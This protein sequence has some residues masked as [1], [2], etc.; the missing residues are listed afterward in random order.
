MIHGALVFINRTE[1]LRPK[2][3]K[4][5]FSDPLLF[6]QT[7]PELMEN[8]ET[9]D[10]WTLQSW[11]EAYT[12]L[13]WDH[14]K[15]G[16]RRSAGDPNDDKSLRTYLERRLNED[17]GNLLEQRANDLRDSD[18]YIASKLAGGGAGLIPFA[19]PFVTRGLG[20]SFA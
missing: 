10:L 17:C 20:K 4:S 5:T 13:A 2:R 15:H 8:I 19:G 3:Q 6:M 14:L 7:Y 12:A 1:N 16:R 9:M 11:L 18:K